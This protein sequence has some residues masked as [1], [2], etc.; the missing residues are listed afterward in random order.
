[1]DQMDH[2]ITIMHGAGGYSGREKEILYCVIYRGE[3]NTMKKL[4]AEA[5]P[6]AFMIVGQVNEVL[7]EGFMNMR[8]VK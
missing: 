8:Y 4:V 7:G 2:G 1:M 6:K 3:V 5:D